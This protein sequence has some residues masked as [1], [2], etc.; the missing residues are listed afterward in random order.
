[1]SSLAKR[2][3]GE[4]HLSEVSRAGGF[5]QL[6]ERR[7]DLRRCARGRA[8]SSAQRKAP[9]PLCF[10]CTL[11]AVRSLAHESILVRKGTRGIQA[12]RALWLQARRQGWRFFLLMM[13]GTLGWQPIR[14]TP[15]Y[16][17]RSTLAEWVNDHAVARGVYR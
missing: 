12:Y 4:Q 9:A 13:P 10:E 6:W 7:C 3:V 15:R 8:R 2:R 17:S 1:M 11:W 5:A 16:G 14:P